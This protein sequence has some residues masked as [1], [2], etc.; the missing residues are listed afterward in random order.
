MPSKKRKV[1]KYLVT[2]DDTQTVIVEATNRVDAKNHKDIPKGVT[3]NSI[4]HTSL[5]TC[6]GKKDSPCGY[7]ISDAEANYCSRCGK[8]I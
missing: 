1:F 6:K 7:L 4:E 8:K 2:Y 3:I 5:I